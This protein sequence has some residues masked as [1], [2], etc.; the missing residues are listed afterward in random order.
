VDE[1]IQSVLRSRMLLVALVVVGLLA[2]LVW[3]G[4]R[5]LIY[6]PGDAAAAPVGL[7][8]EVTVRTSDGLRL[9][10][11]LMPATGPDLAMAVL[12]APGNAGNR[13]DR[14]PLARAIAS[15]GLTVLLLEYRGYGGNPGRPSES[16]LGRDVR[17]GLAYLTDAGYGPDRIVYF[18]ESL[19]AAVVGELAVETPPA[20]LVLRSPFVDLASVAAQ[21]YP[22]L[23]VRFLLR[24]RYLLGEH[25]TRIAVPTTVIYGT[26]DSIVAPAQSRLVADQ[27]AGPVRVVAVDGA[28]HNDAKL[29]NGPPVVDAVT[30]LVARVRGPG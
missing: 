21:H 26:A 9:T 24:D 12:V 14:M 15:A 25:V 6:L 11:R 29:A 30:E 10:A 19:G 3:V 28:D 20:G 4:Q 7:A 5:R 2:V 22:Y 8:R 27:T 16:G 1:I 18:G 23:P 17:A 13:A